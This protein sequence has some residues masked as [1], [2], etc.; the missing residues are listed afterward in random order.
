MPVKLSYLPPPPMLETNS[1]T[2]VLIS[3]IHPV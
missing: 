1:P 3:K 2:A